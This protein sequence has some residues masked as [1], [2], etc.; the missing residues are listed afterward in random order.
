M[1]LIY[2]LRSIINIT[3]KR[4]WAQRGIT[5]ATTIGLIM[6]VA[7]LTTVPLYAD[8]VNFRL[9]EERL[10][11][12]SDNRN[13]PPFAYMFNYIGSWHGALQW[14]EI[15]AADTYMM[16]V[17]GQSLGLPQQEA[18]RHFE[19]DLYRIFADDSNYDEDELALLK[20]AT[21]SEIADHITYV[22]GG[23]PRAVDGTSDTIEVLISQ[24][25]ADSFGW[26]VGES[27]IAFNGRIENGQQTFPIKVTGIWQPT[28]ANDPFW[29]YKPQV[30]DE[31][32]MI[33]E[34][35]YHKRI[36][37]MIDDEVYLAT[38]YFVLDGSRVGTRQVDGLV[39]SAATVEQ[40]LQR[41]RPNASTLITPIDALWPYQ[42]AV[43]ELS[44][45]LFAFNV[46][47]VGL[48]LAFVGLVGG[49]AANQRRTEFA[50]L[51]SRG[52][53]VGQLLGMALLENLILGLIAFVVGIGLA[54][55]LTQFMG[56]SRSFLDFSAESM[57]RVA[58]SQDALWAGVI[59]L[60]IAVLAQLIPM[61]ATARYTIVNYKL[62]QARSTIRP[63]W[64]RMSLDLILLA[65]TA[66]GFYTLQGQGSLV[67]TS[68]NEGATSNFSNPLFFLLPALTIFAVTLLFLRLLP[69]VMR[70][71]SW[72]LQQTNSITLLQA[73]RYLAR[74]PQ[75]YNTP[76]I[77]LVLT[78]SFSVFTASLARTLDFHL[79]DQAFYAAGA[80]LNMFTTPATE[81][82]NSA[83]AILERDSSFVFLPVSE[84][85]TLTGVTSAARVGKFP[86]VA[87]IGTSKVG[88]TF[89]G[90]DRNDFQE[91]AYWR[92]DFSQY[93]FGS[94]MN[95]LGSVQD[96][97]LVPRSLLA[98]N[99][100]QGGDTIRVEVRLDD[101]TVE[102]D[103]QIVGTFDYWP[104]WYPGDDK[105]LLVGN[106]N[107]LFERAGAEFPYRVWIKTD[108][109]ISESRLRSELNR[110]QLGGSTWKEPFTKIDK[111]LNEPQR[112]GLFGL[113]SVGFVSAALL[114]VFGLFL[115]AL[116]SY[117]RRVVE[118]GVLRAVGLSTRRMAALIAWELALLILSGVILGTTLGVGVS[119][120]YVPFLQIGATSAEQI[121]PYVVEIAWGAVSQVY[122]LFILL[123]LIALGTLITLALRMRVF[124][125]IKLGETV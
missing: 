1:I 73:T 15:A 70:G 60:V 101:A 88:G 108:G 100:L 38:W 98:Q 31:L 113:L 84:Y 25:L 59:A 34:A 121:P 10:S 2:R 87:N 111:G 7:L 35:T 32:M 55:A 45:L 120:V 124:M 24:A 116:F 97:V 103:A 107:T 83:F 125:A 91:T 54:L 105:M 46:P 92:W 71:F 72:L 41:L 112:Q 20:F 115:Y 109:P 90:I 80:D 61:M 56:R 51:R 16:G 95:A 119:R 42:N 18:I 52:G 89:M 69:I 81:E 26:Q 23:W 94:L 86:V 85:K 67:L 37:P 27:Y 122:I 78:V 29:L 12:Q 123:F 6:A 49:L 99:G 30:F 14:E 65:I 104:T 62:L 63:I 11:S 82:N 9:L 44:V 75:H 40:Q 22:E 33:P 117:R 102:Y 106:L 8:A 47:T 36:A 39:N 48:V 64:Q 21:T 76:L 53:T 114:T 96:G 19:T 66:Y 3:L 5:I 57:L 28:N 43:R 4:L 17:G 58:L 77:L 93:R 68:A 50:V 79:Y 13:R 118:L 110:R 74:T